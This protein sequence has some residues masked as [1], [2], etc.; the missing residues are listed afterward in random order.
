VNRLDTLYIV[1]AGVAA[2][3]WARKARRGWPERF[4]KTADVVDR[5]T[6]DGQR[7][8]RLLLHA[9]SVGEVNALRE[10]VPLLTAEA[11]IVISASTDT[12][13]N[14]A[15][16]LFASTCDVVRYPLDFSWS[17]R[18][19]LDAVG[20]DAVA[21][22]E[23]ELWPNF[24]R[25]CRR[26]GVPVCIINGRLSERSFRGYRRMKRLIGPTFA[27][28]EFAAVQDAA[29]AAR[30]EHMG[31]P[32]G[33]CLIAGSMKW[34][35]ARIEDDV[36]GAEAFAEEMGIRR[37]AGAPPL[38]VAGSTAEGEEELLHR[39]CEQIG[40]VQLLCAPRK[41]ERFDEAARALPGCRRRTQT[42]GGPPP[43]TPPAPHRYL[44]DTIGE[45]RKAYA[46]ADVVVMGRTFGRLYGSDPVE[47][48]G[49][50]KPVVVGPRNSDFQAIVEAFRV[51]GGIAEATRDTLGE[52]LGSLL[53]D[54]VRRRELA[55]RGR[56]CI[57][58]NQGASERHAELL[59]SLV[60]RQELAGAPG[61]SESINHT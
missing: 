48:I 36:P 59:L 50:G 20:P 38:V 3:F 29:Y 19:F 18:R 56:A 2:P 54:P 37:G 55:A 27:T 34:D 30:F 41:P 13:L 43:Q 45:L 5:F 49:L 25:E 40:E 28:L 35:T 11:H 53:A 22:V 31:V 52:V 8:P 23:L 39:V 21:L 12:G 1:L 10:L 57:E 14:R 9:V 58:E 42:A 26:R 33:S 4:G 6:T 47:P 44:L 60:Q 15:Q 16:D 7:L 61:R 17:V 51:A 46:L 24:V 32:P